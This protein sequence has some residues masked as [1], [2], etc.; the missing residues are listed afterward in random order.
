MGR[1]RF[2]DLKTKL[3]KLMGPFYRISSPEGVKLFLSMS[4]IN[5]SPCFT[6]PKIEQW[7]LIPLLYP[8]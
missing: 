2:N 1:E 4:Y 7:V 8:F 5:T 6:I 3:K